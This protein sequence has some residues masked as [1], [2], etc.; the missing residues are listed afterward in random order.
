MRDFGSLRT[1]I[2]AAEP[3]QPEVP[4]GTPRYPE[5]PRGTPRYSEALHLHVLVI[6]TCRFRFGERVALAAG[7]VG[8]FLF[9]G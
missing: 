5:V 7:A 2:A 3:E 6:V 8:G 4:R 1:V 9:G